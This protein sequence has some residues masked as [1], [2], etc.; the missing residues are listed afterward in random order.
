MQIQ[1]ILKCLYLVEVR[2]LWWVS[3][4]VPQNPVEA[5]PFQPVTTFR[6]NALGRPD[7]TIKVFCHTAQQEELPTF[8]E[9]M[10]KDRPNGFFWLEILIPFSKI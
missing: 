2:T 10:R 8:I 6:A 3:N 1:C 5:T 7:A 9:Q 4:K